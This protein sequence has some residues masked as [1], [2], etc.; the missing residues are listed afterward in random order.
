MKMADLQK[1]VDAIN[2]TASQER[3]N[4]HITLGDLVSA[5]EKA[6]PDAWVIYDTTEESA[7]SAPQS[8][9][10]YYCDLSFPPSSTPIKVREL[11]NEA[12]DAI[13]STF[14]G[15]KGGDYRMS[16]DTPLWASPY[17]S[18]NGVGIMD[19]KTIGGRVVLI[20]KQID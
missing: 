11:L 13:G 2:A 14:E 12:R 8:Y 20:T 6:D 19:V 15:Y 4:Y 5:L 1:L 16:S 3:A 18:A 17:G 9:R 10:G 7:P